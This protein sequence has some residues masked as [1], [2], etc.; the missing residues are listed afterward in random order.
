[1][2]SDCTRGLLIEPDLSGWMTLWKGSKNSVKLKQNKESVMWRAGSIGEEAAY[3][4]AQRDDCPWG[5]EGQAAQLM[6]CRQLQQGKDGRITRTA[7]L[8]VTTSLL[9]PVAGIRE[10]LRRTH[11]DPKNSGIQRELGVQVQNGGSDWG[12]PGQQPASW[13][14]ND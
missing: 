7:G 13:G 4:R 2:L 5:G 12:K 3:P 9:G 10:E 1:M 11:K 6:V 8:F 14:Q